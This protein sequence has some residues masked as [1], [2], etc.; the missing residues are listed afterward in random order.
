M[1]STFF[2]S[3]SSKKILSFGHGCILVKV[4]R[5]PYS[6]G[7]STRLLSAES[8]PT[9]YSA[10]P[11]TGILFAE[12]RLYRFQTRLTRFSSLLSSLL[13]RAV[14]QFLLCWIPAQPVSD[15]TQR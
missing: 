4:D 2:S 6:V 9:P 11:G 15:S 13:N 14:S 10:D 3:K 8:R 5:V 1:S 7:L 12:Y